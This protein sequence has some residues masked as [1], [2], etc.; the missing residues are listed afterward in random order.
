[1]QCP[2]YKVQEMTSQTQ[3]RT[4]VWK[5]LMIPLEEWIPSD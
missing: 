1:M 4:N 2:L 5:R 3:T